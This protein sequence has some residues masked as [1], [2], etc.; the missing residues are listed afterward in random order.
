MANAHHPNQTHT[1]P[2]GMSEFPTT[3][4][5]SKS[6]KARGRSKE[7]DRS[8][9]KERSRSRPA[10]Q[11]PAVNLGPPLK[12]V[13]S[14]TKWENRIA[15]MFGRNRKGSNVAQ[16][17][18]EEAMYRQ[19]YPHI[20]P[21]YHPAVDQGPASAP[22]TKSRFL[23]FGL[24]RP[25]R[26]SQPQLSTVPSAPEFRRTQTNYEPLH[27]RVG[28]SLDIGLPPG[29]V[30]VGIPIDRFGRITLHTPEKTNEKDR[31]KSLKLGHRHGNE[32]IEG[33]VRID[34][35]TSVHRSHDH[36]RSPREGN[37]PSLEDGRRP[38]FDASHRPDAPRQRS[39]SNTSQPQIVSRTSGGVP[40][41]GGVHVQ[42]R[43]DAYGS[44]AGTYSY[45]ISQTHSGHRP[46]SHRRDIGVAPGVHVDRHG[47]IIIEPPGKANSGQDRVRSL[48]LGGRG[49][50]E[51][52]EGPTRV[53]IRGI[54]V[55]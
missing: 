41:S 9:R 26:P 3:A 50:N 10:E 14:R 11:D 37:R 19:G 22:P 29:Q 32:Q 15:G 45:T 44:S 40:G 6:S 38:S 34:A 17:E 18:T 39:T 1:R 48:K 24:G 36:G 25:R 35:R 28:A 12:R 42:Q 21:S 13:S 55:R 20:P 53:D 51:M 33:P 7:R 8:A 54:G 27:P 43:V 16:P 52:L 49:G 47:R 2:P 23:P 46:D 30:P 31:V 4:A 5:S